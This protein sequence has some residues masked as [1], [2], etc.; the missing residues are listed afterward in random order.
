MT[1]RSPIGSGKDLLHAFTKIQAQQSVNPTT[2]VI[3]SAKSV[4][5]DIGYLDLVTYVRSVFIVTGSKCQ[6]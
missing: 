6:R 3:V 4:L 5:S 2:V 1:S